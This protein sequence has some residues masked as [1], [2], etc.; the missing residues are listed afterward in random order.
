MFGRGKKENTRKSKKNK[1]ANLDY[2]Q[3]DFD[4]EVSQGDQMDPLGD[5]GMEY[6]ETEKALLRLHQ[7]LIDFYTKHNPDNVNEEVLTI[8][9][10]FFIDAGGVALNRK[11]MEKYGEDL[12]TFKRI[13]SNVNPADVSKRISATLGRMDRASKGKELEDMGIDI[14]PPPSKIETTATRESARKSQRDFGQSPTFDHRPKKKKVI[15]DPELATYKKKMNKEI[16]ANAGDV[17]DLLNM[18]EDVPEDDPTEDPALK[19]YL[20]DKPRNPKVSDRD[21]IEAFY[22]IHDENKLDNEA[23]MEK[24]VNWVKTNS[25]E[26]LSNKLRVKYNHGL[27]DYDKLSRRRRNL[28][29]LLTDFYG[30][31]DKPK[32]NTRW[33]ILKILSWTMKNGVVALNKKFNTRY[34][35]PVVQVGHSD[36]DNEL[37]I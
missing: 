28:E 37:D 26:K 25:L 3:Q 22:S 18:E 10:Q 32:L 17:D 5:T 35:H 24:F 27:E 34:G 21:K 1:Q 33:T 4:I 14:P 9:M 30:K 36:Q 6:G 11:L 2:A 29:N 13:K 16:E 31:H 15:D 8:L 19:L 23:S 20:L 7:N 12:Q